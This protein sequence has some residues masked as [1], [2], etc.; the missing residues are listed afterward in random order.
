[1]VSYHNT[2]QRYNTED[3][4]LRSPNQ[5]SWEHSGKCVLTP[6]SA[7]VEYRW[8]LCATH[9]KTKGIASPYLGAPL[10]INGTTPCFTNRLFK[11]TASAQAHNCI[12]CMS[13]HI[14][15]SSLTHSVLCSWVVQYKYLMHVTSLNHATSLS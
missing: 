9:G 2:T 7:S 5:N 1:L 12:L 13:S 8:Q 6:I 11:L 15:K 4:D 14:S 10:S 3:L